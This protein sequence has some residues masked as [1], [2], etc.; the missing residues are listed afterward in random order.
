ML[1]RWTKV[2]GRP[3]TR[4][5]PDVA[6]V[7]EISNVHPAPSEVVVRRSYEPIIRQLIYSLSR[8]T[9]RAG[10]SLQLDTFDGERARYQSWNAALLEPRTRPTL[11]FFREPGVHA[12]S[13]SNMLSVMLGGRFSRRTWGRLGADLADPTGTVPV[14]VGGEAGGRTQIEFVLDVPQDPAIDL[15]VLT[16]SAR[17]GDLTLDNYVQG[18][19]RTLSEDLESDP[20]TEF[21]A[22]HLSSAFYDNYGSF[23]DGMGETGAWPDA[24][25]VSASPDHPATV[26]VVLEPQA[27]GRTLLVIGGSWND[28][29]QQNTVISDLVPVVFELDR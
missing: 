22:R 27:A 8:W 28:G 7:P 15:F 25:T 6:V 5:S 9:S 12:F 29:E 3:V 2:G 11:W 19:L 20:D 10:P 4:V 17:R 14:Q 18:Y 21:A 26:S 23:L 1:R 16:P 24:E 13:R